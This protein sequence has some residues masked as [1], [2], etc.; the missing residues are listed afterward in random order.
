MGYGLLAH[1][2]VKFVQ[3]VAKRIHLDNLCNLWRKNLTFVVF[4]FF[5][6]SAC[7]GHFNYAPIDQSL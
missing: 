3:F 6:V 5:A 1:Q 4:V 2:L 7:M